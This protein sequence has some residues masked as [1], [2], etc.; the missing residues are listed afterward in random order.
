MLIKLNNFPKWTPNK[1]WILLRWDFC[2]KSYIHMEKSLVVQWS[3][4]SPEI[5][6][7][8]FWIFLHFTHA[9][10]PHSGRSFGQLA[11]KPWPQK[12]LQTTPNQTWQAHVCGMR[13]TL[14]KYHENFGCCVVALRGYIR[15]CVV[16]KVVA[17]SPINWLLKTQMSLLQ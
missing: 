8:F 1:M 16:P 15:K 10:C 4:A 3:Q 13:I 5:Q 2:L 11:L 7:F 9:Y 12:E 17:F 14:C 6:I